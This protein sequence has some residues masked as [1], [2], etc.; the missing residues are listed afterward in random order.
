MKRSKG[1][2][3]RRWGQRWREVEAREFLAA[4][5]E[6]PTPGRASLQQPANVGQG[7]QEGK[8]PD[9]IFASKPVGVLS[10]GSFQLWRMDK[11]GSHLAHG[12]EGQIAS[13]LCAGDSI[14]A[15]VGEQGHRIAAQGQSL[16]LGDLIASELA[17]P[18]GQ[19][20]G[21]YLSRF[22]SSLFI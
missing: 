17:H 22:E 11:T 9:V 21:S 19:A 15:Q 12:F 20:V 8:G 16:G 10:D 6:S 4:W 13:A 1:S 18:G 5:R 3:R 7:M 2:H 14:V